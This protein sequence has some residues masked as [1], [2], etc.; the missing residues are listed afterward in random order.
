MPPLG[1]HLALCV[2]CK[3]TPAYSRVY[4]S[5]WTLCVGPS[6]CALLMGK[7]P[8]VWTRFIRDSIVCVNAIEKLSVGDDAGGPRTTKNRKHVEGYSRRM[9]AY[10]FHILN[11]VP[12]LSLAGK[13]NNRD[14]I[15]LSTHIFR[16][17]LKR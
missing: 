12:I 8:L 17:S 10:I 14:S 15:I 13:K 11:C 6:S 3:Y 16:E 9:C 5:E 1:P 7:S 4:V 2:V